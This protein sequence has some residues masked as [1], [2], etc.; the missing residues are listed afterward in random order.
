MK[1][2]RTRRKS[3]KREAQGRRPT[4]RDARAAGARRARKSEE[5]RR[6]SGKSPVR[7]AATPKPAARVRGRSRKK[8]LAQTRVSRKEPAVRSQIRRERLKRPA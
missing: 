4:A 1:K 3:R 5:N 2:A 6:D 8:K 7:L